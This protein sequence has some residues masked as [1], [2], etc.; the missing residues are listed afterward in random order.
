MDR[1]VDPC[2]DFYQYSCGNFLNVIQVPAEIQDPSFFSLAEERNVIKLK[3]LL[4]NND[5]TL[6][7]KVS[8]ALNKTKQFYNTC[9]KLTAVHKRGITP[10]VQ[11]NTSIPT[12]YSSKFSLKLHENEDNWAR[13]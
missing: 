5:Y 8:D 13:W 6:F 10:L 2:Q 1:S 4:E 12:Y 9:M 11:V 3:Q 7:G